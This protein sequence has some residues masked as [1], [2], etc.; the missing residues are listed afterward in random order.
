[1][2]IKD[3][4]NHFLD[5]DPRWKEWPTGNAPT[6]D[7]EGCFFLEKGHVMEYLRVG[8][9]AKKIITLFFGPTE[10]VIPCH[11][12]FSCMVSLDPI[13]KASFS[14]H[15]VFSTIRKFPE[16]KVHYRGVRDQ[17]KKKVETRIYEL[18]SLTGPE[19]FDRLKETQPW[20]FSKV[21][22]KDIASYLGISR[23]I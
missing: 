21:N 22:E 15:A 9:D 8:K 19:R 5:I 11:P 2:I 4:F 18:K 14:Y 10:F 12:I 17:Y 23:T 3:L 20:V 6:P 13:S 1:M 7:R 16:S